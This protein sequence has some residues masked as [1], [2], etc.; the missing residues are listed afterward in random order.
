MNEYEILAKD[1]MQQ[2]G[3]IGW[4]FGWNSKRS[5]FGTCK[6]RPKVIELSKLLTPL[7]PKD[8]VINTILHEIAHALVGI[9]HHH[10][11]V[12]R[13]KFVSLG[14]DG[15]R[16]SSLDNVD[17]S[18]IGGNNWVAICVNGHVHVKFRQPTRTASCGQCSSRFDK[19]YILTYERQ[20]RTA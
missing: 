19:R 15:K 5:S 13:R 8:E 6:Y 17:K 1:L 20:L 2:H 9:G 7:R 10:D 16:C 3:L 18:Q 11:E 12:W 14:G 4:R